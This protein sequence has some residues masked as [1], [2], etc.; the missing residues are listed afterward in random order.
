LEF[1]ESGQ[2]I[3]AKHAERR[4]AQ[5]ILQ[6]VTGK[7]V[8]PPFEDWEDALYDPPPRIDPKQP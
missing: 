6:Y 7:T 2:V 3:N 4:A 8:E 1:D 5:Y